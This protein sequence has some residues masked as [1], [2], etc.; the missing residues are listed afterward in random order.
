MSYCILD[1]HPACNQ[2]AKVK[3]LSQGEKLHMKTL[4]TDTL[5][6]LCKNGLVPKLQGEFCIEGL[7]G[8]S[9]EQDDLMLVG[10]KK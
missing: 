6:L 3:M 4:I 5:V 8:I 7:I 2:L 1:I 10:L 9:M